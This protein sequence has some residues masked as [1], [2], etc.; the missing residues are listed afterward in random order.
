MLIEDAKV[1]QRKIIHIDMDAFFASVEQRD[2]PKLRGKP[3]AVG[4]SPTGRG[5]VATC[6][7]EARKF[8]VHSAMPA[9]TAARLCPKII[10]V[11]PRF[12]AY[13]A[14]SNQIR[15]IFHEYT[16][17][18]EP[19]SL[20]E[21]YLDVTENKFNIASAIAIAAGIREKIL[22]E[23]R[24]TATA[25]VSFNK[26]LAKMASGHKKPNGLNFIPLEKA[27]DYIDQLEI[28]KFYG[29]GEKTAE[30]MKALGIH[31]G[32]DLREHDLR[33]LVRNFGKAGRYYFDIAR[34]I[35]FRR[36]T[37]DR[38][39][40]SVSVEDTFQ[41]DLSDLSQLHSELERLV[42]LL[43]PRLQKY[44]IKAKTF[45]LKVKYGDFQIASRSQTDANG[46]FEASQMILTAKDLLTKTEAGDRPIRL[47]GVG[48]SNFEGLENRSDP[49]GQLRINFPDYDWDAFDSKRSYFD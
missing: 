6:S 46:Y 1:P 16:D 22:K 48:L 2:N 30:R 41:T 40:K 49:E 8:G 31:N 7:Y 39:M 23:T 47:L 3:I 24:L 18:V 25:G 12:E 15:D 21:A 26:F 14:V 10:F 28:Q 38:P 11:R 4:G 13:K 36:V 35:D 29:I 32:S 20:D 44:E 43:I 33:F 42:G 17:L 37:P 19:L 34:G 45:N 27:Q 9:A 5:V